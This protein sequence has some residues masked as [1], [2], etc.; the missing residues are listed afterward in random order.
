MRIVAL[1]GIR[2]EALYLEKCLTHLHRNGIQ[3]CVIDNDST[4]DSLAIARKFAPDCVIGIE[5]VP[6][7]GVYDW[8]AILRKKEELTGI[9]PADWFIHH[10][11]DEI[12]SSATPDIT[13]SQAIDAV[14]RQGYNAINFDEFVFL[15]M[16]EE[17]KGFEGVDYVT[18]MQYY[19]YFLPSATHRVNAWKNMGQPVDLVSSGGHQARFEGQNICP[20]N[21]VLRHYIGLSRDHL[22]RKYTGRIYSQKEVTER[23]WHGKRASFKAGDLRLPSREMMKKMRQ[24]GKWDRSEPLTQHYFLGD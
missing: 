20:D 3:V 5:R 15:P 1:L 23:K 7:Q 9:I 10:D 6:F 16:A 14:D 24:N 13:L 22:I 4:D 12:R 17:Q 2:N 18:A 19:Y 21:L 8:V 11:G